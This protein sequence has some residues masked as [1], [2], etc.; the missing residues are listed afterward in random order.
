MQM[1]I[2]LLVSTQAIWKCSYK[3][4]S[5][6]DRGTL[7][8]LRNLI[9]PRNVVK[10]PTKAVDACEEFFSVCGG[11]KYLFVRDDIAWNDWC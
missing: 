11:S 7:F 1:L 3:C 8:H 10:K 9:N 5:G 2:T 4:S 6:T